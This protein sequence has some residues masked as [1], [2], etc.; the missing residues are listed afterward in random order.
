MQRS[1][2]KIES[3]ESPLKEETLVKSEVEEEVNGNS[4][5][6]SPKESSLEVNQDKTIL[7]EI[8]EERDASKVE[9]PIVEST[10][11]PQNPCDEEEIP[12][13]EDAVQCNISEEQDKIVNVEETTKLGI[14]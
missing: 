3:S 5:A 1:W 14:V 11:S 13:T 4:G 2:K 8:N 9:E 6:E 7:E 10:P 12:D